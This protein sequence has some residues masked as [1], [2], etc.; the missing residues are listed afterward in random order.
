MNTNFEITVTTT[1]GIEGKRVKSYLGVV[2]GETI[3]GTNVF[4]DIF[5]GVRDV[6]GGRSK[7]YEDTVKEARENSLKEMIEKATLKGANAVVGVS[8]SYEVV[9][10]TALMVAVSGTAVV[11][12]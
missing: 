2:S 12:E 3:Y 10:G 1:Q 5:A 11:I 6:I 4:K 8:F 7:A 9:G